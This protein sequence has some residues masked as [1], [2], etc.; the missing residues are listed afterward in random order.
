MLGVKVLTTV[1]G[2][3]SREQA[4]G[5]SPVLAL[6]GDAIS[7]YAFTMRRWDRI[8]QSIRN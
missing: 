7:D 8:G 2:A 5:F 3:S 4:T 1:A 6:P